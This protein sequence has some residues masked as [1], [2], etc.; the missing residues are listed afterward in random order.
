MEGR[1]LFFLCVERREMGGEFRKSTTP[2]KG[3]WRE[4]V[5]VETATGTEL[6]GERRKE[7][8]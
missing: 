6:K 3:G 5:K 4:S 2:P 1:E 8:V 7:M